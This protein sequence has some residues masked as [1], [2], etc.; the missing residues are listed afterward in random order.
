M[1]SS[2]VTKPKDL[3]VHLLISQP[4]NWR[5]LTRSL[6]DQL[7]PDATV[8]APSSSQRSRLGKLVQML[9]AVQHTAEGRLMGTKGA[10]GAESHYCYELLS[11]AQ[12]FNSCS[13]DED[14]L[15]LI[16]RFLK[17]VNARLEGVAVDADASDILHQAFLQIAGAAEQI[18][19]SIHSPPSLP[20]GGHEDGPVHFCDDDEE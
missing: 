8:Q 14:T 16:K 4:E 17:V 15:A 11:R 3:P 10:D 19:K 13:G 20:L 12:A 7:R 1:S 5:S 18:P 6:A 9:R 2:P